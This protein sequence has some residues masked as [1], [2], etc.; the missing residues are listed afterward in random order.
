M[1]RSATKR[2]KRACQ[3]TIFIVKTVA[4]NS[5]CFAILAL[6]TPSD[7][8]IAKVLISRQ[9][10]NRSISAQA[11]AI[12]LLH[13]ILLPRAGLAERI[14]VKPALSLIKDRVSIPSDLFC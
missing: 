4:G 5:P 9:F 14:A 10:L 1:A 11:G 13:R 12:P 2:S 8:H 6:K 3:V 7:A